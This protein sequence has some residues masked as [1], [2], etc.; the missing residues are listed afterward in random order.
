MCVFMCIYVRM[1]ICMCVCMNV[2][3][4]V[5]NIVCMCICMYDQPIKDVDR[6]S[7]TAPI[8]VGPNNLYAHNFFISFV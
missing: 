8:L 7:P 4:Y 1:Y 3:M 5:C 6:G 2:C